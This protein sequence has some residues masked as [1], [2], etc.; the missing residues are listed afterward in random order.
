LDTCSLLTSIHA[1]QASSKGADAAIF[2]GRDIRV[3]LAGR[4]ITDDV[5]SRRTLL[6][7][8]QERRWGLLLPNG[9]GLSL[10]DSC[11]ASPLSDWCNVTTNASLGGPRR[12]YTSSCVRP[13]SLRT[14]FCGG[15][16]TMKAPERYHI[17]SL[18]RLAYGI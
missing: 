6:E 10:G 4:R 17:P 12:G 11:T 15:G 5:N 9:N 18:R 8:I 2:T 1:I 7:G 16:R 14:A 13:P 3:A